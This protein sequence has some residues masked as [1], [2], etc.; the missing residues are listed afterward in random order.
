[1]ILKKIRK[2]KTAINLTDLQQAPVAM[3]LHQKIWSPKW[4]KSKSSEY[5]DSAMHN[6]NEQFTVYLIVRRS[7]IIINMWLHV[8]II[9]ILMFLFRNK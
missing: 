9:I 3:F 4:A 8:H 5:V 6:L 7:D 2:Y 1:M